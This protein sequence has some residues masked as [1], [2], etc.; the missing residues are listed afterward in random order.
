MRS[1][2]DKD[3]T[4]KVAHSVTLCSGPPLSSASPPCCHVLCCAEPKT[5]WEFGFGPQRQRQNKP[6]SWLPGVISSEKSGLSRLEEKA[7]EEKWGEQGPLPPKGAEQNDGLCFL[8]VNGAE[9]RGELSHWLTLPLQRRTTPTMLDNSCSRINYHFLTACCVL[10]KCVCLVDTHRSVNFP[11]PAY[12]QVEV[13]GKAPDGHHPYV[14]WFD[15][16]NTCGG[17]NNMAKP[18]S[19]L[20]DNNNKK[21]KHIRELELEMNKLGG[22]ELIAWVISEL[23][24]E[25]EK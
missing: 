12:G 23:R 4:V 16:Q 6:L 20:N 25:K 17:K 10:I 1:P 22:F 9:E 8:V 7:G 24:S 21:H 19:L 3:A 18:F 15:L 11:L 14:H 13:A 2:Q 5:S